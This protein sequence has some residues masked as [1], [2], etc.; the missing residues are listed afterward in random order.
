ML[1]LT[2]F[3]KKTVLVALVAALALAAL[4]VMN[5]YASGLNDPT[6]PPTAE[7]QQ[8]S[9]ERLERAWAR[10]Q[11]VYERQGRILD[12]ADEMDERIQGLIDRMNENGKDTVALQAALASYEEALKDAHPIYESAKGIL[13]SHQGFD[14]DGKLTDREKAVE[15]VKKLRDKLNEIR[16]IVGEP[17]KALREAIKAF[18]EAHRPADT[19]GTQG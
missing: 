4:P 13:N 2:S 1:K 19:T 5:A 8:P 17:G 10:L 6:D 14:A 16:Q 18:R 12:R 9:N 7:T 15:T 11:R 3:F